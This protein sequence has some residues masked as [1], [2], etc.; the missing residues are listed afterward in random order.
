MVCRW[1]NYHHVIQAHL[2]HLA[3]H[4]HCNHFVH[5]HVNPLECR[6]DHSDHINQAHLG[7]L[8]YR[9]RRG[10]LVHLDYHSPL[11]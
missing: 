6:C 5:H 2:D 1:H 3:F 10:H 11:V 8:A 7:L 4:F 9:C